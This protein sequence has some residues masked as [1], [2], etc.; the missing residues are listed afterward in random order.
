VRRGVVVLDRDGTINVERHYL[1]DP[2]QVELL[3]GAAEGLRHLRDLGME[4]IVVTNQSGVGRGYFTG[5]TL[6]AIHARLVECLAAEGVELGGIYVCPHVPAD[7]CRCRK[8]GPGLLEEAGRE[9]GFEPREAFVIGDKASDIE[10]GRRA[11]STTLLVRTGYG[12]EVAGAGD[13]TADHV[14]ADLREAARVIEGLI[15]PD[16][17][18]SAAGQRS[19][20]NGI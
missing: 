17:A 11:G 14:V 10:L 3:A 13:V 16:E 4:L 20:R 19:A 7:G 18:I 2:A 15:G 1:A 8:P 5:D 6:T 9:R 12:A